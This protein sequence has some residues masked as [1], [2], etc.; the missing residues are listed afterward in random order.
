MISN[1]LCKVE[2]S[3]YTNAWR[4]EIVIEGARVVPTILTASKINVENASKVIYKNY[5]E[6]LSKLGL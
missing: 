6:I 4:S 2:H 1:V 5:P 3:D